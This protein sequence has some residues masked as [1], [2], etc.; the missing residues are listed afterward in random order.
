MG[1]QERQPELSK[2]D[3]AALDFIIADMEDRGIEKIGLAPDEFITILTPVLRTITITFT[4]EIMYSDLQGDWLKDKAIT[5]E[6]LEAIRS[7]E[8]T[9]EKLV[10]LRNKLPKP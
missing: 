8:I 6:A 5:E 2:A 1:E 4:R 9:L 3:L 7:D 10:E